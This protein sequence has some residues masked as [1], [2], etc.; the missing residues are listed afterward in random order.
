MKY[1]RKRMTRFCSEFGFES[2]PD[3]KTIRTFAKESDYD[4]PSPVFSAHQKCN[5]GNDKMLYYIASRFR[6]P[7]KFEDLIYLSQVTQLECISDATEHWRRNKGRCNGSLYWQFN[8]C[9]GVCSWAGM[10]YYGNYKA[11]QYRSKHFFAPV[12][13]SVEDV[14]NK[15][16]IYIL[17]DKNEEKKLTLK[18]KIFHFEKGIIQKKSRDFTV[19]ALQNK[20]CFTLFEKQLKAKY[21][22]AE[23]GVKAELYENGEL[24]S[25]KT[26]LFKP[27]KDLKMRAPEMKLTT[28]LEGDEIAITV[29]SDIFARLV[30]VESSLS[31]LPLS[32]NYFDILPGESVTVR[33][34]LDEKFTAEEQMNSFSLM[35]A[36]VIEPKSTELYDL[37][38]RLKLAARPDSIGQFVYYAQK[39]K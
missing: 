34:K 3:I 22:L 38:Q 9:W 5:S 21:N 29:K 31:T 37:A 27:E 7:K 10:D 33:M 35:C 32:D 19:D 2:L 36:N 15:V 17:N 26:Y 12:S 11:L 14:D 6:I 8:D 28:A 13:V 18:C 39:T 25:E 1:Y 4:I 20:L 24:L 23:I 16:N 30:R